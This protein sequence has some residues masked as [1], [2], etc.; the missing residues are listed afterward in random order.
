MMKTGA[1]RR[2]Q[3]VAYAREWAY[4]RNPAYYDFSELGGDCTNFASQVLY[5]G[6]GV[7]N[8]TPTTGW[9]YINLNNRSPSWTGVPYF[10]DFLTGNRGVG[11][12]AR[13]AELSE[14]ELGD[15]IQLSFNEVRYAH[16]LAVVS[17]G[18]P[19]TPYNTLVATHTFDAYNRPLSSYSF[20]EMRCIHILGYR[21]W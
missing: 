12:F 6:T 21:N 16:T 13:G 15:F 2:E 3:A 7:M 18:K 10:Y 20:R 14:V 5:A 17:V 19:A 1:Y 8:R 9:Y 11:P 4:G